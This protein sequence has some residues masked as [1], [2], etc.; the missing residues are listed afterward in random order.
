MDLLIYLLYRLLEIYEYVLLARCIMSFFGYNKVYEFLCVLTEPVLRP[1][2]ELLRKTPL[3]NTP[4]DFSVVFAMILIGV[5]EN[6]LA[7]LSRIL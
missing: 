6:C 7:Y 5:T 4:F 2:R 1:I 3:G